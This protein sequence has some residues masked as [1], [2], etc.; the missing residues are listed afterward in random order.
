MYILVYLQ[1]SYIFI[2]HMRLFLECIMGILLMS[3][4]AKNYLFMISIALTLPY[5]I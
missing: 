2:L 3:L 1:Q 5:N 4:N